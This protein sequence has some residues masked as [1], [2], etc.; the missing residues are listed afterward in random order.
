MT[1]GSS[2]TNQSSIHD[3]LINPTNVPQTAIY[4]VTPVSGTS[5]NCE[6]PAFTVTVTV[7]PGPAIGPHTTSICSGETFSV[8]PQNGVP[9]GTIVPPGTTYSW[10]APS[11][12]GGIYGGISGSN[13]TIIGTLI[14]PTNIP[15]DAVYTVMPTT[16][17]CPGPAFTLT[18]TVNPTPV[19]PTL[20]TSICSGGTFSVAPE[21]GNPTSATIVP[22]GTI[23]TWPIPIFGG[24]GGS[25]GI[26][27]DSIKG[28]LVNPSNIAITATY[29]V[30]PTSGAQGQCVGDT[31]NV[32]VTINPVPFIPDMHT[33]VCSGDMFTVSPV[34]N[35]P[36]GTIVPNGTMYSWSTPTLPPGLTNGIA[37]GPYWNI[38][39]TLINHTNAP[40]TATYTVTPT[41]SI[42]CPGNSFV[43]TVTVNPT[44]EIPDYF[45][46]I[47]TGESFSIS[48][49]VNYGP[50]TIVPVNTK[51]SWPAP[52]APV[53]LNGGVGDTNTFISGTLVNT[54][55]VPLTAIYTVTP[56]SGNCPG[57]SFTVTVIVN[58]TPLVPNYDISI[59]SG[60]V[61]TIE[62]PNHPPDTIVPAGTTYTWPVPIAPNII[63]GNSGL[64]EHNITDT[65]FNQTASVQTAIYTVVP[66][67]GTSG[68]CEGPSFT[69]TVHV[70][71]IPIV[72]DLTDSVCS[73][74]PFCVTLPLSNPNDS[75]IIP[76]G[77]T[78]SWPAPVVTGGLTGGD[79]AINHSGICDSLHNPTNENQYITYTV[80]PVFNGCTGADFTVSITVFPTPEIP[81]FVDTVCSGDTFA[82]KPINN[83]P[84]GTTIV[85]VATSYSW[86]APSGTGF[87]GGVAGSDTSISGSLINTTNTLQ[88]AVYTVTP[89]AVSPMN[90][91]GLPFTL[92]VYIFPVPKIPDLDTSVCSEEHFVVIPENDPP[93]SIVPVGTVYTWNEPWIQPPGVITGGV[94]G[95]AVGNINGTLANMTNFPSVAIYTVTPQSG[96]CP[97]PDFTLTVTVNP[98]PTANFEYQNDHSIEPF[99]GTIIFENLSLDATYFWWDLGDGTQEN[100]YEMIF[101]HR[102]MYDTMVTVMLVAYN[103][104]E[105]YD[106]IVKNVIVD[107]LQGLYVPN[108]FSPTGINSEVNTFYAVG[109]GLK[110]FHIEV[111]DRWGNKLWE[112]N[113]IDEFG[114]PTGKWDGT[115]KGKPLPTGDY[116]WKAFAIFKDDSIW[117][118]MDYKQY[119]HGGK[120]KQGKLTLIR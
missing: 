92:T 87:I 91:E 67:S 44:P 56:T 116:V 77:T 32:I 19:I 31:F 6:G 86:T 17:T 101:S 41:T 54:T 110:T 45:D 104:Y 15:Q 9:F 62:P 117:T 112:S 68:N 111:F 103:Q 10:T 11:V 30:I 107:P 38:Y 70:N 21:N 109:Y 34:N 66:K 115:Y 2:G 93:V 14:N 33:S 105:C 3:T 119:D 1:G 94:A 98:K 100:I 90:C 18:V 29:S 26:N 50:D 8:S 7:N 64:N 97:G 12:S 80:T 51:Y 81:N 58:P 74:E 95:S 28:T 85:P 120:R 71:P 118:G 75:I 42:P 102:Y 96:F 46:T 48:P 108:A 113:E 106:T 53:G 99:D 78:Y 37:G 89:T 52:T 88:I 73:N 36:P 60:E 59:C 47:C 35:V 5:G 49:A 55:D 57:N 72:P 76:V 43:L 61:F 63:G 82:I 20:T 69:I 65:L 25:S 40:L 22:S 83:A 84:Q 16:P 39:G 13:D 4:T 24:S 79:S 27:L 114:R 23:Y